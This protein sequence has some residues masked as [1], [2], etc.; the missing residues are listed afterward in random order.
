MSGLFA[1]VL[2]VLDADEAERGAV[3]EDE[4]VRR[5][6]PV[7]RPQHRIQHGLVEQ[8]IPASKGV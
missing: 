5:Q 8:E 3:R 2:A 4:A 1:L 7:A 6:P